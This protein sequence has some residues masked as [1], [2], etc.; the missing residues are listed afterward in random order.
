MIY[1]PEFITE[2]LILKG[3]TENDIGSYE[4]YFIDYEVIRHLA[5]VVP[6]PYPK[7]GVAT[8]VKE[9]I[10]PK[11]GNDK[12]VWGIFMR[13]HPADLIGI[14]D[15]WRPGTPE[16]RGF[17]L[18][19]E[20]WGQGIMTEAVIPIIDFAFQELNFETLLF[21]NAKGNTPSRRIKEKTGATFLRIEP[22]SFVDPTYREKE[23]WELKKDSWYK[24]KKG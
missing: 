9:Q 14:V 16:N 23:L 15:L 5:S 24:L 4:K 12:W 17:W 21:S 1:P 6:W 13:A 10:L 8:F 19:R 20:F 2:R 7:D 18:G 11:Q 22:A 3:V